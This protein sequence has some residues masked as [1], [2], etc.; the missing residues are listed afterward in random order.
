MFGDSDSVSSFEGFSNTRQTDRAVSTAGGLYVQPPPASDVM[1]KSP[2]KT[3]LSFSPHSKLQAQDEVPPTHSEMEL[4]LLGGGLSCSLGR[5]LPGGSSVVVRR[6]KSDPR[7]ITGGPQARLSLVHRRVR[8]RLGGISRRSE[9]I[10]SVN[11][12]G[13]TGVDQFQGAPGSGVRSLN[14]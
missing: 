4:G 5:F 9:S 11:R 7:G 6:V 14:F 12:V 2:R 13:S 3:F 1:E 10:R 8:C